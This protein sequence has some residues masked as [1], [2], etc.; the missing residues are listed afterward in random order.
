MSQTISIGNEI[1]DGYPETNK[2]VQNNIKWLSSLE[3]FYRERA[4]LEKEYSEKL[5]QLTK[6]YFSKK[7]SETVALSVGNTPATTPGSLESA[8]QVAWNEIL[9]QTEIIASDH[10]KFANDI[11]F[12]I[13]EQLKTLSSRCSCL[14]YTSRCV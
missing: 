8:S 12:N 2:W 14:L 6:E 9:S 11:S 3:A 13:C 5:S 7:S 1:K 4:K 10:N